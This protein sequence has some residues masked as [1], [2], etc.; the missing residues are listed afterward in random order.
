MG[1]SR[2]FSG[3]IALLAVAALLGSAGA[4][5]ATSSKP[6][7]D[8]STPTAVDS[9]LVSKGIDPASVVKQVGLNNYAGPNCPGDG[10]NCTTATRVAQIAAPGGQ[11]VDECTESTFVE[12]DCVIMQ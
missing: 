6:V 7:I 3:A 2:I 5:T 1:R 8:I 4:A 10:W 9:Y 12:G 11:N